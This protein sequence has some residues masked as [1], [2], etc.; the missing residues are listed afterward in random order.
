LIAQCLILIVAEKAKF[1]MLAIYQQ[2]INMYISHFLVQA[3]GSGIL[4]AFC[5]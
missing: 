5:Q 1:I 3:A 2:K 4:F